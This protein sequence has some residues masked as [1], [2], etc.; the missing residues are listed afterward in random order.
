MIFYQKSPAMTDCN[1]C[2]LT[3]DRHRIS[4]DLIHNERLQY[5]QYEHIPEKSD[6]DG[7]QIVLAI[8]SRYGCS[9]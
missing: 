5:R 8:L 4:A 7:M 6:I 3:H 2:S 9:Q 1:K